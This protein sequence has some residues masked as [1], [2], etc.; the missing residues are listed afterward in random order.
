MTDNVNQAKGDKDPAEW[1]PPLSSYHCMYARMWVS[2][3]SVYKLTVDSAEKAKLSDIL[4]G[5]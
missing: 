3:K 2:V 1:L 5:C 4:N